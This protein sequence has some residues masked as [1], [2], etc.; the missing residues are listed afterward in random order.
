VYT[1]YNKL[2]HNPQQARES[3]T[4]DECWHQNYNKQQPANQSTCQ[5]HAQTRATAAYHKPE[6]LSQLIIT[7]TPSGA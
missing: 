4:L 2:E 3:K 6:K 5:V 7:R 1:S